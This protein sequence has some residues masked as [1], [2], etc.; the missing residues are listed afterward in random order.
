MCTDALLVLPDDLR[1]AFKDPYGPIYTD[2]EELLADAGEPVIAVGD[3]V[4]YH[5]EKAGY[6]P[7]VALIDGRTER[8]AVDEEINQALGGGDVR[9]ANPAGTLTAE[10]L[11]ALVDAI[12]A[13]EPRRLTVDGEEDLAAIP[14]VL[15]APCG[16]TV[17]YG[18]P[19]EGMVAI[20]ITEETKSTFR[21]L[22]GKLDGDAESALS[23]LE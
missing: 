23:L 16:S 9:I 8:E 20:S 6:S 21:E 15:A 3:I 22:L 17:V 18:Q 10:L 14:A 12:D 19:Q 4:T 11:S 5:L 2:A 1:S 13:A 7:Q